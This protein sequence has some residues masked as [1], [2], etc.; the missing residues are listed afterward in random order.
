[1]NSEVIRQLMLEQQR[2]WVIPYI[3]Y[4]QAIEMCRK[5]KVPVTIEEAHDFIR[6]YVEKTLKE[7]EDKNE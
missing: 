7:M 2:P 1:M 4:M 3:G 6:N 5:S